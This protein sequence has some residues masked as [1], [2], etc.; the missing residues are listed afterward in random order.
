MTWLQRY[1]LRHFLRVSFWYVPVVWIVAA[2]VAVPAMRWLDQQ[3]GWSWFNFTPEGARGILT[4]SA[5]S[6]LTFVVF[7]VSTLLLAVQ[8]A[9]SQLTPRIIN[10]IFSLR[11]V[12]V[13]VGVFVFAYAFT[14]GALGR[15]EAQHVPQLLVF[16]AVLSSLISIGLF[17]WFVPEVSANLQPVAVLRHM[18][19]QGRLVIDSV[20]PGGVFFANP[21]AAPMEVEAPRD[22]SRIIKHV[23]SSGTFMVFAVKELV[24]AAEASNVVIELVPQVG[25]FVSPSDPFFRIYPAD[26]HI[27]EVALHQMV[28]IGRSRTLEQDPAFAF[29]IM[30]DI[31]SRAL[32]PAVNDPTTAVLALDQI[33]C[34]LGYV[35]EKQ[36][37]P[38]REFDARG[39]LRL[40]YRMPQWEDFVALAVSEIRLF[41][42]ACI[43]VPRRLR[44]MLE[45]LIAV[46]PEARAPALRQELASLQS[47][48]ERNYADAED[49]RRAQT[50]DRQGIGGSSTR[51]PGA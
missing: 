5:S 35:G 38:G 18:W 25:D 13:S 31:A 36:L 6:M 1:R 32:S 26:R 24:A 40:I 46:L 48:V 29:R 7:A 15:I 50:G 37:N 2:V 44:A 41:G 51:R 30:V 3:T 14:L 20:Y 27:D 45:H 28:A 23:G 34:L 33:Q 19:E 39:K 22:S 21:P 11:K 47:A 9:A 12:Q 10:F 43:Q 49:Q 8:L 16:V 4:G 42:A 17:L